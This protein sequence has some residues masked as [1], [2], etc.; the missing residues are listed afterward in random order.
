MTLGR[1]LRPVLVCLSVSGAGLAT[2]SCGMVDDPHRF[3]T[4]AAHVADIDLG[5]G[6]PRASAAPVRTAAEQ[7]LRPALA[8]SGRPAG[9]Q[10]EVM[11]PHALWDARDNDLRGV[12]TAAAK[13][14]APRLIEAAAPRI[15]AAAETEVRARLAQPLSQ[16]QGLRPAIHRPTPQT[17]ATIQLGAYSSEAAARSAW[18]TV[19]DGAARQALGGLSPIFERVS[20]NG[21]SLTRLKV[22]APADAATAICRAARVSDPWCARRT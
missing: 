7:G 15:V 10:V 3:E 19:K 18:A 1:M 9:L 17:R 13:E 5:D 20:V 2:A 6:G 16:A 12:V 22:A 4:M 21:R 11:D 14:A 8:P